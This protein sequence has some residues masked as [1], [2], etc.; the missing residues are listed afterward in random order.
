MLSQEREAER[1]YQEV[2]I[3]CRTE[4]SPTIRNKNLR[5]VLGH[6]GTCLESWRWEHWG[7]IVILGYIPGGGQS[8]LH[9]KPQNLKRRKRKRRI[10]RRR[11]RRKRKA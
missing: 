4:V 2:G 1:C 7:L 9:D 3:S 11:K 5:N 8:E 10:E 6:G